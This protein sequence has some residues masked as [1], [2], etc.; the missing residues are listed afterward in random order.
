MFSR[1]V[2]AFSS[3]GVRSP[4]NRRF[5]WAQVIS[6][7]NGKKFAFWYVFLKMVC[8]WRFF[9]IIKFCHSKKIDFR[10]RKKRGSSTDVLHK[11]T[12]LPIILCG[13]DYNAHLHSGRVIQEMTNKKGKINRLIFYK[14]SYLRLVPGGTQTTYK[15]IFLSST[16]SFNHFFMNVRLLNK[17]RGMLI[18]F[19][20][21]FQGLR[22]LL[23]RV[24]FFFQNILYLMVWGCLFL[25]LRLMFLQNVPG[26]TFIAGAA[27]IPK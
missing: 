3:L 18:I 20:T 11:V 1:A 27:S 16:Y 6:T 10:A 7:W 21:F 4:W 12:I 24:I 9:C 19:L 5:L 26:A 22:S 15:V 17:H 2:K 14:L 25:E 23:E 13:L 8:I